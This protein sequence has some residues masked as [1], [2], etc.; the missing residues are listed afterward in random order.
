MRKKAYLIKDEKTIE[1]NNDE[2]MIG[3]SSHVDL[4]IRDNMV[5]QIHCRI[6]KKNDVFY[7]EDLHTMNGT[8]IDGKQLPADTPTRIEDGQM[9]WIANVVYEFRIV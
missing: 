5:S 7:V 8:Y 9:L 6:I 1:I 4:D 3:R 2:F